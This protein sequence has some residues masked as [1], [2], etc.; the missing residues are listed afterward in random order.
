LFGSIYFLF[1]CVKAL[2]FTITGGH[3]MIDNLEHTP[4]PWDTFWHEEN[5]RLKIGSWCFTHNGHDPVCFRRVSLA[6]KTAKANAILI[7]AAPEL[8]MALHNITKVYWGV[9]DNKNGDGG[10]EPPYV[11]IRARAAITKATGGRS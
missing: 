11:I 8:L 7:A 4:G 10:K 1:F 3:K 5:L 6:N 9:D 2:M